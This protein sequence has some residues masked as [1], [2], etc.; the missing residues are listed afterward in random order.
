MRVLVISPYLP[1]RE[2]GHGGG[3]SVRS[4]VAGLARRHDV[5]L[6]ALMRPGEEDLAD[7][8][9][10]DLGA[11]V[12]TVPFLDARARGLDRL[13]LV[14]RRLAA[15]AKSL[16]SG[17][18]L[19]MEKYGEPAVLRAVAA[20]VAAADPDAV[21][22]EYLQLFRILQD[23]KRRRDAGDGPGAARPRLF[24]NTHELSSLPRRRRMEQTGNPLLKMK[25]RLQAD[26]WRRLERA[27]TREAD[28]TLCVT[29]QDRDLLLAAGGRN[30][31]AVPLGVDTDKVRPVWR[32]DGPDR[33]L[34][35][36]SFGHRPNRI[37]AK[38]LIDKVWP[39]V[40]QCTETGQLVLAGRGSESVIR[41]LGTTDESVVALGYVEDLEDLYR[42]CR[43]F[44]APLAEG[45]GIKI[46]ILEAMARGIPVVTTEIGAEGI[47]KPGDDAL[48]LAPPDE[49]FAGAVIKALEDRETTRAR[50]RRAREVID[51]RFSWSAITERLTLMYEGR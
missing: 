16:V 29:E 34:F 21:Q 45:G 24:L 36:G 25:L 23:L 13:R 17:Y 48:T 32:E 7:G 15:A 41:A 30:C 6:V 9:A 1:H 8:V 33:L 18:P 10:A 4:L 42:Q 3:V 43:L 12:V 27:A 28:T 26:S 49:T 47:V 38:F 40:A 44:V 46:K 51:E 35:V 14:G 20:A 39:V 2:I 22:V 11:T 5:T 37:A 19:Y 31:A 50:A